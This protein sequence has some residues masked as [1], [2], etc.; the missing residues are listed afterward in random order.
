[1]EIGSIN[2][3]GPRES[4]MRP[5]EER[6]PQ[7]PAPEV[8]DEFGYDED[9]VETE[10]QR[11]RG[12]LESASDAIGTAVEMAW[13]EFERKRDEVAPNFAGRWL[14]RETVF[15]NR[16]A[17]P[18]DSQGRLVRSHPNAHL[19]QGLSMGLLTEAVT[20]VGPAIQHAVIGADGLP[21]EFF[22]YGY[23]SEDGSKKQLVEGI[24]EYDCE[25]AGWRAGVTS[26][27]LRPLPIHGTVTY[28]QGWQETTELVYEAGKIVERPRP[29]GMFF[30]H[31][32]EL[33]VVVSDP[34]LEHAWDQR[35]VIWRDEVTVSE[36]WGNRRRLDTEDTIVRLAT[37]PVAKPESVRRGRYTNLEALMVDESELAQMT[38]LPHQTGGDQ[39]A[40]GP[41]GE[42]MHG[43]RTERL[44]RRLE[45]Q[46]KFPV[47]SMLRTGELT[48][49][50]FTALIPE[51]I[52]IDTDRTTGEV[53]PVEGEDLFRLCD[54]VVWYVT[55]VEGE[56]GWHVI[57]LRPC[58][59]RRGRTEL[60]HATFIASGCFYGHGIDQMAGDLAD[61]ADMFFNHLSAILANNADPPMVVDQKL[62]GHFRDDEL[63]KLHQNGA[64]FKFDSAS[65]ASGLSAADA[66]GYLLKPLEPATFNFVSL[67]Q[68]L[69]NTRA[70]ATQ[71]GKGAAADTGTDTAAEISMQQAS[72]DR[73]LRAVVDSIAKVN[74]VTRS[75][76]LWLEDLDTFN[77]DQQL[78]DLAMR[79]AGQSGAGAKTIWPKGQKTV[80]LADEFSVRHIGD[81]AVRR[82]VTAQMTLKL[83]STFGNVIGPEA[84]RRL[85]R[86]GIESL[87]MDPDRILPE[88]RE[89]VDPMDEYN[90][91]IKGGARP[92]ISPKDDDSLHV[93]AH[94][95][96]AQRVQEMIASGVVVEDV[97]L[98]A[99]FDMLQTHVLEH[100]KAFNEKYAEMEAR[101]QAEAGGGGP[102][103]AGGGKKAIDKE[104]AGGGDRAPAADGDKSAKG[105]AAAAAMEG[106]VT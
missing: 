33:D 74:L 46:G 103:G 58:P 82:E 48:M 78:T 54:Q 14:D 24:A 20:T 26:G 57:D 91:I 2:S 23:R 97:D 25:R 53:I 77:T 38:Y 102:P 51:P 98:L 83:A 70:M 44:R 72:L 30:F 52:G 55:V 35:T 37:G 96:Q 18:T 92:A 81:G 59:Y 43:L 88:D 56:R 19:H 49:R 64:T 5:L 41:R 101:K 67:I 16:Q 50:A 95:M 90:L 31:W 80:S 75:W 11:A 3:W 40:K 65:V 79:V 87:G 36:L 76:S 94:S 73:R 7:A 28:R 32:P 93:R 104:M 13:S 106:G 1:V 39:Q 99:V 105:M 22:P 4:L 86:I 42:G 21:V 6:N 68:G 12:D 61:T 66:V 71:V 62:A 34:E 89:S 17:A 47:G 8:E 69:F 45:L 84:S 63:K 60:L 15:A 29:G 9:P 100:V 27:L 85:F 10:F